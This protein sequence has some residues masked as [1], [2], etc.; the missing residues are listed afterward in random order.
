M[1]IYALGEQEPSISGE[2][3]V[4]P[5]ATVIG[6]VTLGA[7]SS[8][9]PGAVLR[10][11]GGEILIG[12]RTSVQ[13]NAVLH[14]T[15]QWP[16]MVGDDCVLG[17]LIHLEGCSI[18]DHVLI[19]NGS[20]VLHRCVIRTG[21]IVAANAVVLNDTEVPT[22]AIAVGTPATIKEGRARREDIDEGSREYIRRAIR[23]RTDLRRLD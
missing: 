6:S 18:E 16:T 2:A 20:M 17:H 1:A 8:V 11:D 7:L 3:F 13:D 23:Y 21:S 4:H 12:E 15:P 10:G 9:W 22:G 5:E 14:T 19:G